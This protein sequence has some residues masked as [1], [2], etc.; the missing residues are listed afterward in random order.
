MGAGRGVLIE[1]IIL[2]SL[3]M[4]RCGRGGQR[5]HL[6]SVC[7]MKAVKCLDAPRAI[8]HNLLSH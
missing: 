5:E 3:H 2:W 8:D 6:L 4:G 1:W 7:N